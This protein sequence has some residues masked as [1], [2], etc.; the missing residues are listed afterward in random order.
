MELRHMKLPIWKSLIVERYKL[1][2]NSN[3]L[4]IDKEVCHEDWKNPRHEFLL[5]SHQI[6]VSFL[7]YVCIPYKLALWKVLQI[8]FYCKRLEYIK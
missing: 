4:T 1:Y 8:V 5:L 3:I 7:V 2:L 6:Y